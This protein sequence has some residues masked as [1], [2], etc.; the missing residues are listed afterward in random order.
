MVNEDA[1]CVEILTQIA[2]VV[3]ASERVALILLEYERR[4]A[5]RNCRSFHFL[6]DFSLPWSRIH[7]GF[8]GER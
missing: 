2:S 7:R 6:V 8:I 4:A 5:R 1:Y 3:S